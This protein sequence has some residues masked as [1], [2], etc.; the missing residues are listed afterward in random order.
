MTDYFLV[1]RTRQ[2]EN[3]RFIRGLHVPPESGQP[4]RDV[5]LFEHLGDDA[6]VLQLGQH[7]AV[8]MIET[9]PAEVSMLGSFQIV[10]QLFQLGQQSV[11]RMGNVFDVEGE[12]GKDI[13]AGGDRFHVVVRQGGERE[14]VIDV[15]HHFVWIAYD[16]IRVNQGG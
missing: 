10:A 3:V 8:E 16:V 5:E 13:R 7:H 2:L 9:V 4:G 11:G 1:G 14:V 12:L 6:D 15:L